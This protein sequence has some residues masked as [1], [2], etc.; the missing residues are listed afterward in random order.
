PVVLSFVAHGCGRFC[1]RES[2]WRRASLSKPPVQSGADTIVRHALQRG[3]VNAYRQVRTDLGAQTSAPGDADLRTE[4]DGRNP[5]VVG[6]VP[7]KRVALL[8][9]AGDIELQRD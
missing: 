5:R 4:K 9:F 2:F 6:F 3:V 7:L 8:G 1:F